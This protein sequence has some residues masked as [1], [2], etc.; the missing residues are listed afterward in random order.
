[1]SGLRVEEFCELTHLSIRRYTQPD[2]TV[3]PLL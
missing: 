3:I 2:G 1:L